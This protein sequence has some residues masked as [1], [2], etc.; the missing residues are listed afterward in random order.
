MQIEMLKDLRWSF[1]GDIRSFTKGQ[2]VDLDEDTAL[3]MIRHSYAAKCEVK[4]L[5]V[6]Y[7]NK[8]LVVEKQDKAEEEEKEVKADFKPKK[9]K[10]K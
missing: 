5:H 1:N 7:E 2:V 10:K 3:E 6:E 4:Q 9:N 8:M